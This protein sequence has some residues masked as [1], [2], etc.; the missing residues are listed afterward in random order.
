MCTQSIAH[1]NIVCLLV[2]CLPCYENVRLCLAKQHG[3]NDCLEECCFDSKC[4]SQ[5]SICYAFLLR[6]RVRGVCYKHHYRLCVWWRVP[7][8][9]ARNLVCPWVHML[10]THMYISLSS[11]RTCM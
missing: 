8:C 10:Y 5:V 4:I 6:N 11:W 9:I 2:V 1:T 7:V 3:S